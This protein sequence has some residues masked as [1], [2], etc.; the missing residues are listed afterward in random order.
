MKALITG[1]SRGIGKKIADKLWVAGHEVITVARTEADIIHDFSKPLSAGKASEFPKDI[2]ILVNNVGGNMGINDPH[3]LAGWGEVMELNFWSAV[4]MSNIV[5]P[6]MIN[7]KWGRVINTCST[8]SVEN[9][10]AVPYCSAKAAL[11]AYTH[12]MGRVLAPTGVIMTGLIVGA[13]ATKGGHWDHQTEEHK[14]KYLKERCPLGRFGEERSVA[15][16]VAFLC[17]DKADFFQG[18]LLSIDGGQ[19]R[20]W[21]L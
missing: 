12:S 7:N 14:A 18:A 2:D 4:S 17:T 21:Q 3:V 9:N 16:F 13:I 5:L 6:H 1:A 10:G 11:A 8:S 19:T 20:G 15:D